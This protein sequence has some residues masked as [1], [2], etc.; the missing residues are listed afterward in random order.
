MGIVSSKEEK[1]RD[2]FE[3]DMGVH[4]A[5]LMGFAKPYTSR[6]PKRELEKFLKLALDEAWSTRRVVGTP[7][8]T[9][10]RWWSMC[11]RFAALTGGPWTQVYSHKV[12]TV[13][14]RE[15][16]REENI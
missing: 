3:R 16:G 2:A 5:Q 10:L 8:Y 1:E 11:L 9:L 4:V 15:L 13:T 6:L 14:G 12:I 7:G